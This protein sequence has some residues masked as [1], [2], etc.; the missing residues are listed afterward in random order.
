[1]NKRRRKELL[2]RREKRVGKKK[3]RRHDFVAKI[4]LYK[5]DQHY[6][7][8]IKQ[9]VLDQIER[10]FDKG[11]KLYKRKGE[12]KQLIRRELLASRKAEDG[13][14]GDVD[15]HT[16]LDDSVVEYFHELAKQ[17]LRGE[18]RVDIKRYKYKTRKGYFYLAKGRKGFLKREIAE[19][20]YKPK[21]KEY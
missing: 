12:M 1:M 18:I 14:L 11:I 3:D 15:R 2:R 6:E 13:T 10:D 20:F 7:E 4:N 9:A 19:E 8:Y 17:D 21:I 5:P 16:Y